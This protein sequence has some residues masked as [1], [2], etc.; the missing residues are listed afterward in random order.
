[1]RAI[2][3][4]QTFIL[5]QNERNIPPL[6]IHLASRKYCEMDPIGKDQLFLT[7]PL[8]H[9]FWEEGNLDVVFFLKDGMV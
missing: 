9:I 5:I 4:L 1:M 7:V 6:I 3:D 8:N 2:P